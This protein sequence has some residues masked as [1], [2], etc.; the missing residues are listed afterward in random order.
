MKKKLLVRSSWFI[1]FLSFVFLYPIP[2]TL[3]PTH[4]QEKSIE[5]TSIYKIADTEAV[6]GDILITSADGLIRTTKVADDKVF[7]VLQDQ[8]LLV[9]RII[10]AEGKPVA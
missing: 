8:P 9:F 2:Y 1:V 10:D 6:D 5:V 7:G 4:A 3:Y